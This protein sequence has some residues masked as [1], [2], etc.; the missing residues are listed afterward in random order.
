MGAD[1]G[2]PRR[3]QQEREAKMKT[4]Y[5]ESAHQIREQDRA[6]VIHP[7]SSLA[8]NKEE[9][10][11]VMTGSEGVHV[12]DAEGNR[13][14]DGIGGL[15]CV[16]AGY[17]REEII[18]AIAQQLRELPFYSAFNNLTNRPAAVLSEKLAELAPGDLNHVFFGTGGSI[19]NDTAVRMVHHHNNLIGKPYRKKILSRQ[20]AYHGSTHLAIALTG[21]VYQTGWDGATDLV[22]YLSAPYAYRRP[23][24]MSEEEFLE[25]LIKEMEDA[26]L[27]LGPENVAAFIAEPIMGA[28]GVIVPP[29]GYHKRTWEVC[30]KYGI[31]YIS[32][33]VVTG[34]GRL[35]HMFSSLEV[36]GVQPDIITAAKGISSGYQPLSATLVSDEI[37]ETLAK[38]DS[39]F[40]HGFTYS[41]HPAAC[42]AGLKNIEI[43]EREGICEQVRET[44]PYFEKTLKELESLDIV[45]EVRGSHF[46]MCIENVADKAT[47]ELFPAEVDIGKRIAQHCQ[48]RGLIVRPLGHLNI[49]SPPLILSKSQI[50]E[51]GDILERSIK[52]VMNDLASKAA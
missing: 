36:F 38:P 5:E 46:M 33:E 25:S 39:A 28:G 26:I 27:Q 30:R 24:G 43:L 16:N 13:F 4:N 14:Y 20:L 45:G 12:Y 42:A 41:C 47:K 50:D 52:A 9:G 1:A 37:F 44:G 22:H 29:T 35:G 19:A 21:P 17:G 31:F 7:F 23:E 32:D 49:L 18:D 6:H 11:T 2:H 48:S 34:F 40:Y 8:T 15:W 10:C 51:I 3:T